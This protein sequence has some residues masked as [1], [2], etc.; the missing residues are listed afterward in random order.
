[1]STTRT[2]ADALANPGETNAQVAA[3][4]NDAGVNTPP[5][6]TEAP[7]DLVRLPGGL[8]RD[9]KV[10]KTA[11]VRELTGSDEEALSR[12]LR[13]GS[14]FR[15]MD[16]LVERGTESVGDLPA[17]KELL[18]QLLVGDRDELAIAIRIATYG[19]AME[20]ER[21]K[22]P[23]CGSLSDIAF[24]LKDDI[25]R[26]ASDDLSRDLTFEVELRKG[27][28]AVVRLPNGKDQ[29]ALYEDEDWTSAERNTKLL[30]LCVQTYTDPKGQ[31]F[32]IRAFPSVVLSLS[33]PDRQTILREISERQPGPRYNEIKFKHEECQTEVILALGIGDL[34][35]DLISFL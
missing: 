22:C 6:I 27:A 1:M 3:V 5:E 20:V 24:S 28:K 2:R 15:F 34:F 30:S 26:V 18:K 25:E 31:S 14:L 4:L 16:V 33:I 35:R 17:T 23:A 7:D 12:A 19:E 10:T 29:D 13:S 11:V 21:W 32:N 8:V 9:G